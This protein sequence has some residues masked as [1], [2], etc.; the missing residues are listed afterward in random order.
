VGSLSQYDD[1]SVP[2]VIE[3]DNDVFKAIKRLQPTKSVGM[4]RIPSFNTSV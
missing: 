1:I 2:G 4:D 3:D